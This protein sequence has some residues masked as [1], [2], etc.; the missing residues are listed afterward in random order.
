MD[1]QKIKN[2]G[3]VL[4]LF[5]L[6]LLFGYQCPFQKITGLPCPGCNMTTS[7]YY[8]LKGNLNASFYYHALLIPTLLV[9]I[10]CVLF[11]SNEKRMKAILM[12]WCAMMILYY[13]YRMIFVFPNAP[14]VYD[15]TSLIYQILLKIKL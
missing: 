14:M 11:G 8:L 9:G 5:L 3:I 7:L 13:I 15:T 6:L 12:V 4:I 10:V 2:L 1:S